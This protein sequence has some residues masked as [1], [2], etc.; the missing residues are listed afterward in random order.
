MISIATETSTCF[1]TTQFV[2]NIKSN[3]NVR[4]S[5]GVSISVTKK[6]MILV[7]HDIS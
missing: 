1:C 3:S 6:G 2:K 4:T 7:L 5:G